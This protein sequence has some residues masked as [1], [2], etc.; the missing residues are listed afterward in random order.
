MKVETKIVFYSRGHS[1]DI[2]HVKQEVII[3]ENC[4]D[5]AKSTA[6][7]DSLFNFIGDDTNKNDQSDSDN[8]LFS[9]NSNTK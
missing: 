8:G 9:L 2:Q 5:D 1:E 3:N 6:S 4:D 7:I